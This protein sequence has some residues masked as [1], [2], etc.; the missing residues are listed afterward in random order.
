MHHGLLERS[1]SPDRP[2]A[3]HADL[4]LLCRTTHLHGKG[5]DL[6]EQ[7]DRQHDEILIAAEKCLHSWT[8]A[9]E[10]VCPSLSH[11]TGQQRS[12]FGYAPIL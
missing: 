5:D 12:R 7:N 1:N 9:G 8:D 2:H 3:D 10:P 4:T 11:L 6:G